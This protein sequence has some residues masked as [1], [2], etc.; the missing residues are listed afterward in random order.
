MIEKQDNELQMV[1]YNYKKGVDIS[2]FVGDLKSQYVSKY[3]GNN[4]MIKL[5]EN[6]QIDGN[7]KYS[8]IKNIPLVEVEGRKMISKIT[9]D[10]IRLL[11]K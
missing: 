2:Q 9:E 1:K 4:Q 6:I 3:K 5:I 11:S 10:L 7:D 8:W